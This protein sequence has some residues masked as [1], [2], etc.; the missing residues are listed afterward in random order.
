MRG[1]TRSVMTI[2]GRNAGDLL[3]RLLAVG[4]RFGDEAPALH[5]LL[6]AHARRR[7]VFDDQHT[8]GDRF[9][10]IVDGGYCTRVGNSHRM[11]SFS[12]VIFTVCAGTGS[13]ASTTFG[14]KFGDLIRWRGTCTLR[15]HDL[16][17]RGRLDNICES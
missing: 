16:V 1:I 15:N 13:C 17:G 12:H 6:Q 14:E 3:E 2:A 5:Q 7:V 11:S 4:G 10:R 9:R 8:L